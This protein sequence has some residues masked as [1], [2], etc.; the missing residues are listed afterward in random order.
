MSSYAMLSY[1]W[2]SK[3]VYDYFVGGFRNKLRMFLD[4]ELQQPAPHNGWLQWDETAMAAGE[5]VSSECA[6]LARNASALVLLVDRFSRESEWCEIELRAFRKA[7][8]QLDGVFPV[9][10]EP[11]PA[12]DRSRGLWD[13]VDALIALNVYDDSGVPM[14]PDEPRVVAEAKRLA[15]SLAPYLSRSALRVRPALPSDVDDDTVRIFLCAS[16][17]SAEHARKDLLADLTIVGG[18]GVRITATVDPNPIDLDATLRACKAAL[19]C[20]DV[21]VHFFGDVPRWRTSGAYL[22]QS[23]LSHALWLS[24]H[25]EHRV[26]VW[27]SASCPIEAWVTA[28]ITASLRSRSMVTISPGTREDLRRRVTEVL[29]SARLPRT[30]DQRT[31]LC[32]LRGGVVGST[33]EALTSAGLNVEMI[34]Q[35]AGADFL[36]VL[37]SKVKGAARIVVVPES[38]SLERALSQLTMLGRVLDAAAYAGIREV[39]P[40]DQAALTPELLV[41]VGWSL[42]VTT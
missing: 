21:S 30:G 25:G 17:G 1:S 28:E 33:F 42:R 32:V 41:K 23:L 5:P 24:Q 18:P 3:E 39:H 19:A 9:R 8:T 40:S 14:R 12:G 36:Q 26:I 4:C 20:A 11:I 35:S 31:L 6:S 16:D 34:N 15:A 2:K 29:Q 37:I 38:A 22:N 10:L 27:L 7:R 13:E